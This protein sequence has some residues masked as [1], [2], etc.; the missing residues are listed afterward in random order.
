MKRKLIHPLW[1]HIPTLVLLA[2]YIVYWL[3][4]IDHLPTRIPIQ[5]GV[6][7]QAITYGSPWLVLE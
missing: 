2:G 3:T 4:Q 7:G 5:F 1:V 6:H